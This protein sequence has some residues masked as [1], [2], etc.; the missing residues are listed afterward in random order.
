MLIALAGLPGTGKSALAQRL[1]RALPAIV[2]DKDAV[3]AALF[4]LQE[5]EY[6]TTQDD[7]CLSIML[8]VAGY[9]LHK[10]PTKYIFLDGRPFSRRYQIATVVT[11][12]RELSTE[13]KIIE[14]VCSD[15]TAKR[16]LEHDIRHETH[17]ARN[18]D[19]A[20]YLSMKAHFEPI[21][22]SKVVIDTDD[23]LESCARRC[24]DSIKNDVSLG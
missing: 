17:V 16:R 13:L 11:A 20:L 4:P 5:I 23:D 9:I 12:A 6:S 22:E 1:A 8:Q 7:F 2:L 21:V 18:R 10:N 14:C 24:L 15:A 19:Y 3:R